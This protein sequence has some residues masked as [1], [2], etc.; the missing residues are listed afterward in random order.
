MV[1]TGGKLQGSGDAARLDL[2]D[3]MRGNA[4]EAVRGLHSVFPG[5]GHEP[6]RV[7]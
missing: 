4:V 5:H 1:L 7:V 6:A 3:V 2:A